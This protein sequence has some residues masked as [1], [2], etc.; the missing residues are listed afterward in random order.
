MKN[1]RMTN[2]IELFIDIP[3]FGLPIDRFRLI[4][5]I[6]PPFRPS[7]NTRTFSYFSLI[8]QKGEMTYQNGQIIPQTESVYTAVKSTDP[9]VLQILSS[10]P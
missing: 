3:T 10:S 5:I 6:S 9:R 8:T 4:R 2:D 1:R 7:P